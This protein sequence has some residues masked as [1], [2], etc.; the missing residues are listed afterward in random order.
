MTVEQIASEVAQLVAELAAVPG[1]VAV[2]LGGSR[3]TGT[4]RP[5]SDWD[6]AVITRLPSS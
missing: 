2:A 4:A 3:A 1:G 5:D 6:L